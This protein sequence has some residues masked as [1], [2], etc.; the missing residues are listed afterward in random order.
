[1]PLAHKQI[2]EA[3]RIHSPMRQQEDIVN[4]MNKLAVRDLPRTGQASP[5]SLKMS[6][7]T[8]LGY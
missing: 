8:Y 5:I 2:L 6:V 3:S 7:T 4:A 1:M